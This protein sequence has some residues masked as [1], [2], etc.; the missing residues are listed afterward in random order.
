MS[1]RI[2]AEFAALEK[3]AKEFETVLG[4]L[5]RHLTELDRHLRASLASWEGDA[6]TAYWVAHHEWQ[7]AAADMAEQIAWLR[8]TLVTAHGNYRTSLHANLTMWDV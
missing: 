3:A 6:A 1:D 2:M 7:A 8:R 4:A 5:R